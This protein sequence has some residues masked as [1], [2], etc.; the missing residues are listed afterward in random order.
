M[1]NKVHISQIDDRHIFEESGINLLAAGGSIIG[2]IFQVSGYTHITGFVYSDVAS[3]LNGLIIE[4]A[5]QESDF[6]AGVATANVT[7]T[8]LT[9]TGA[10]ITNNA[11]SVQV[12]GSY[13]RVIYINGATPQGTFRAVFEA[14][15]MRGL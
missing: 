13:V 12:V 2:D 7:S 9:I 1:T 15:V 8:A 4:Q 11:L 6:P 10:D 3:A 5:V 14:R